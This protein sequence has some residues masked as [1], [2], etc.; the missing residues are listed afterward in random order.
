MWQQGFTD[1]QAAKNWKK[2][3][4]EKSWSSAKSLCMTAGIRRECQDRNAPVRAPCVIDKIAVETELLMAEGLSSPFLCRF[5]R[6]KKECAAGIADQ[7]T[8]L[9][10][11]CSHFIDSPF[12]RTGILDR[13]PIHRDMLAAAEMAKLAFIVNVVINEKKKTVAAFAG[14]YLTA[15]RK[16][17][18]YM[19]DFSR[20][21]RFRRMWS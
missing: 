15:H 16:G 2:S 14:N 10:N 4:A 8:V 12:A 21:L 13:N 11:H 3:S 5:F 18:D 17:C 1:R 7:S 20:R 9:G 6:W 19:L